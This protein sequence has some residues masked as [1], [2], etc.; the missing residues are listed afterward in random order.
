MNPYP[1]C[2]FPFSYSCEP[3]KRAAVMAVEH[4]RCACMWYAH[5]TGE[6]SLYSTRRSLSW[7]IVCV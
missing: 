5:C 7:W 2:L 1:V 4:L 3:N 6:F